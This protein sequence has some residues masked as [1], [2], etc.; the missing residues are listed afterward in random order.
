MNPDEFRTAIADES[1][2]S[3]I[4]LRLWEQPLDDTEP[5]WHIWAFVPDHDDAELVSGHLLVDD[6]GAAL[7]FECLNEAYRHVR[8]SGYRLGIRVEDQI[9]EPEDSD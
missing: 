8:A 9:V 5:P 6:E 2:R 4:V 1:L 3:V 7:R